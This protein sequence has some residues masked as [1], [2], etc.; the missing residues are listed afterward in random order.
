MDPADG[1]PEI[2]TADFGRGDARG[3][4]EHGQQEL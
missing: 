3:N 4:P 2:A 1:F